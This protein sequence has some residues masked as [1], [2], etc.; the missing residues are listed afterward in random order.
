MNYTEFILRK[1]YFVFGNI[2]CLRAKTTLLEYES[3]SPPVGLFT[4]CPGGEAH[5]LIS[6]TRLPGNNLKQRDH[7]IKPNSK[8][9]SKT[10]SKGKQAF[11]WKKVRH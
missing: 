8:L 11:T 9:K 6:L 3:W 5:V 2:F 1:K 10:D 4:S 7:A